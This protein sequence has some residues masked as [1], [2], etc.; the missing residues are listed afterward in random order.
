MDVDSQC[1]IDIHWLRGKW[2]PNLKKDTY[3]RRNGQMFT[4]CS[5]VYH[6]RSL[7]LKLLWPA[8]TNSATLG[9]YKAGFVF[10]CSCTETETITSVSLVK[11]YYPQWGL[12]NL[13]Y[14]S[15]LDIWLIS[16]HFVLYWDFIHPECSGSIMH[17]HADKITH[18]RHNL[19]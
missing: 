18:N 9:Q 19:K 17:Q 2:V 7:S 14:W 11:M 5:T 3:G 1:Y 4:Q 6:L 13:N 8:D 12:W 16:V 10:A 15:F